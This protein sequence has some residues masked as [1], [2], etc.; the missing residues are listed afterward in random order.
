[1]NNK[2]VAGLCLL[3]LAAAVAP[4]QAG[5]P[6][7]NQC[8]ECHEPAMDWAGMSVEEIIAAAR[9]PDNKQHKAN[10]SLTDENLRLIIARLMPDEVPEEMPTK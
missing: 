9:V 8:L 5:D 6:D 10:E 7:P 4:V 3:S 2:I 1:M